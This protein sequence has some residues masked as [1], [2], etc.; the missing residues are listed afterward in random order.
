MNNNK[1]KNVKKIVNYFY[2]Y[3]TMQ[4][5]RQNVSNEKQIQVDSCQ[6]ELKELKQN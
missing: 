4:N 1:F 6:L 3:Q 5:H 2:N